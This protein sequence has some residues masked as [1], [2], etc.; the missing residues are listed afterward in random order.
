MIDIPIWVII[1]ISFFLTFA[2]NVKSTSLKDWATFSLFCFSIVCL[3]ALFSKQDISVKIYAMCLLFTTVVFK[4]V[5][6]KK[7]LTTVG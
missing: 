3:A 4:V 2:A 6:M 5:K 1:T 7:L